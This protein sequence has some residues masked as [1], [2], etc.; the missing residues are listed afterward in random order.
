MRVNSI[1]R[2]VSCLAVAGAIAAGFG[3]AAA[4]EGLYAGVGG[5]FVMPQDSDVTGHQ[6]D[7]SPPVDATAKAD[8]G[9]GF[10]GA[11]GYRFADGLRVEG[12]LS[13]R[14]YDF[15]MINVR[16]PGGL[17]AVAGLTPQ[18]FAA[19]QANNSPVLNQLRGPRELDGD[20]RSITL[21]ANL[22]YDID[23]GLDFQ[24]YVG[25]G[26]GLSRVSVKASV[27]GRTTADD[28]DTVM[29]YQFGAGLG[30]KVGGSDDRPVTISLD[31]RY[32]ATQDPTFKGALTG[33][34]FDAEISGS[35]FGIGLRFALLTGPVPGA[36]FSAGTINPLAP[37]PA[38][39]NSAN[40]A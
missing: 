36:S 21:M 22:F 38:C 31:Y 14:R 8:R 6:G 2:R 3:G 12:E 17:A 7:Y 37:A 24:P 25:G 30:Y 33:T 20:V 1:I 35:Y 16:E 18:Q 32:F 27:A 40:Q 39:P 11:V 19:L 13:Y 9:I 28:D 5:G 23:L 26:V 34:P 4:A 29:A 15:D 10:S